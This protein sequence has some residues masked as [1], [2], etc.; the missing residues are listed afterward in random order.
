MVECTVW[1]QIERHDD[2]KTGEEEY[3]NEE[4]EELGG[5]ASFTDLADA[6]EFVAAISGC[7]DIMTKTYQRRGN[8]T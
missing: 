1:S 7:A 2:T 3:T 4:P 8:Q 6:Q 5:F